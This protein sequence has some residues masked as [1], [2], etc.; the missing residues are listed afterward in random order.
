MIYH[1]KRIQFLRIGLQLL[2]ISL[3]P[4]LALLLYLW[5]K[6]VDADNLLSF[7]MGGMLCILV[8]ALLLFRFFRQRIAEDRY[9]L[10]KISKLF[11]KVVR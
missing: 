1:R 2:Y 11:V 6:K 4:L 7:V 3:P 8:E 9:D 10:V 5:L